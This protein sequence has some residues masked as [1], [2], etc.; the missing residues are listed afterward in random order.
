[1]QIT[2]HCNSTQGAWP[3]LCIEGRA[4]VTVQAVG[5][6]CCLKLYRGPEF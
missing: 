2:T 5:K 3:H 4:Y 6:D 1:M